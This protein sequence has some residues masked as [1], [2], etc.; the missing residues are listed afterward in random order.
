MVVSRLFHRYLQRLGARRFEFERTRLDA[1][2]RYFRLALIV[3]LDG[4]DAKRPHLDVVDDDLV[5]PAVAEEGRAADRHFRRTVRL[6]GQL[7]VSAGLE[8]EWL[9]GQRSTGRE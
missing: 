7:V 3:E 6:D 5:D 2:E 8:L 1:D 4:I 9:L